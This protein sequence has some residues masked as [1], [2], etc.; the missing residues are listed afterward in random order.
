VKSV[1]LVP[2]CPLPANTGGKSEMWQHLQI[3]RQMGECHVLSAGRRPVGAGWTDNTIAQFQK[4][5]FRLSLREDACPRMSGRQKL[6]M[7]YAYACKGLRLEKTFWHGNPYHRYA[8]PKEWWL[9]QA[10]GADLAFINY[11]YWAWLPCECPKVVNLLDLWSDFMWGGHGLETA[12]LKQ[13]DLVLVISVDEENTLRSRGISNIVWAPPLAPAETTD[14]SDQV[15][16][17]G[18]DSASNREGL[19]WLASALVGEKIGV[20]VYGSLGK[21]ISSQSLIPVGSYADRYQPY[22]ESGIVLMTTVLGMGVQIKGV[23][24]LAC[25]KAIVARRG[26]MRGL[27]P[28]GGAWVEIDSPEEMVEQVRNLQTDIC[29]RRALASA[30][31]DYYN[32]YLKIEDITMR[33]QKAYTELIFKR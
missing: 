33:L 31:V 17:L 28:P 2:Y 11:S 29:Q 16:L 15:A 5:G 26:A 4:A 12:D 9:N 24:A 8:F 14:D 13:A 22:R 18:S 27:P 32:R 19:E 21:R 25:G 1:V 7:L 10:R 23:E 30:A 6:G 20:R 3:L